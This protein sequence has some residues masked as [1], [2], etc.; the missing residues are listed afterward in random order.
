MEEEDMMFWGEN[1]ISQIIK[2]INKCTNIVNERGFN[3]QSTGLY[4]HNI[5][6]VSYLS[7]TSVSASYTENP[8]RLN[9]QMQ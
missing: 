7:N 2:N 3:I 9:K 5:N 4:K 6:N 1:K 8:E